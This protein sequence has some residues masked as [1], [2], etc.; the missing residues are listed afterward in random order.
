LFP[1]STETF[2]AKTNKPGFPVRA[3][4]T[5]LLGPNLVEPDLRGAHT[6]R[7]RGHSAADRTKA[8]KFDLVRNISSDAA[9]KRSK[10]KPGISADQVGWAGARPRRRSHARYS[11]SVC[12]RRRTRRILD[13]VE[14]IA[15]LEFGGLVERQMVTPIYTAHRRG[16]DA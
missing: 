5:M 16:P 10:D 2:H 11:C 15:N 14:R 9:G 6:D 12:V 7:H 8:V 4:R 13:E 1:K 3:V